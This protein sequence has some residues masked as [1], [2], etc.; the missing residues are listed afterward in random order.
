MILRRSSTRRSI[1]GKVSVGSTPF[2]LTQLRS[3]PHGN[4]VSFPGSA[5]SSLT[6]TIV[7][8]QTG[9]IINNCD[10]ID[11]FS[12]NG[13]VDENGL[14]TYPFQSGDTSL[15]DTPNLTSVLRSLIFNGSYEI[16]QKVFRHEAKFMVTELS[17][18]LNEL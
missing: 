8:T 14:L 10:N 11:F 5:I 1:I 6:M 18:E 7:N 15:I 9:L 4:S 12:R 13:T 16:G 17:D 3:G 2:Y